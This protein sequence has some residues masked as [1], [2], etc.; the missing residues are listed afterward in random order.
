MVFNA[1]PFLFD[2]H[3][4]DQAPLY[5]IISCDRT[6]TMVPYQVSVAQLSAAQLIANNSAPPQL[7]AASSERHLNLAPLQLSADVNS[8][9][10]IQASI[11]RRFFFFPSP[12]QHIF[13]FFATQ[14]DLWR[15]KQ[16]Y[17]V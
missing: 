8:A 15:G 2:Q 7:S 10:K 14:H 16:E 5:S 6:Y 4:I 3:A 9:P 11:Q 1:I 17:N 12:W 13:L